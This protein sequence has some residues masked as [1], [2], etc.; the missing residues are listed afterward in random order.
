MSISL[1]MVLPR[2]S[3]EETA[4]R[5]S[6]YRDEAG[7]ISDDAET[8]LPRSTD[9]SVDGDG[10]GARTEWS[11]RPSWS[12]GIRSRIPDRAVRYWTATVNWVKG[13]DPPRPFRIHPLFPRIQHAPLE[14]LDRY[15]PKRSQRVWLLIGLYI[16]WALAFFLVLHQSSFA[17]E[18]QGQAPIRL[19]CGARYVGDGNACGLNGDQCR[20]FDH[21]SMAFR[22]P[23]HCGR[24]E[25]FRPHAVGDQEVVYQPLVVGG[26]TNASEPISSTIYRGD[27]FICSAA[28]HAG[29]ISDKEGG[30]GMLDLVGEQSSFPR[31]NNHHV[32]SVGFDSYFP[33][34][35]SFRDG[36][37]TQCKDMRWPVMIVGLCFSITLSLFVTSPAV[38]FWS[39]FVALFFQ[40]GLATDPPNADIYSL[41]SIAVGRFLPAAFC[42][43]IIYRYCVRHTLTNLTA[44]FEKTVL[45]LGPAWVGVL[46]NYTFD[47]IPIQRLTPHD[48]QAQPGAIPALITIVLVIFFI[49]LGQA[50]SFRVEGRMPRYLAL[51]AL[52]VAGLLLCLAV[53]R[54]FV[55]IHHYILA[56]LLLPGTAFQNRPSLVYQG[57]L[58]GLFIN[59]IARWG[60]DSLLQT[61]GEILNDVQ[62]GTLL[63]NITVPVVGVLAQNITFRLGPIPPAEK[64]R[65]YDGISVLVNDVERLRSYVDYNSYEDQQQPDERS[66]DANGNEAGSRSGNWW[67]Q[68]RTREWTWHRHNESLPEYFRFA[69]LFGSQVGDYT[70]AGKWDVDGSWVEM[71]TG[72]SR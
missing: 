29:F 66:Q 30:C 61:S 67:S 9:D 6:A 45:W 12:S 1:N 58:V 36:T 7:S 17:S 42:A 14:L 3:D 15:A 8:L 72:P 26:P 51:Y 16:A 22:C 4:G 27:S 28:V 34:S 71:K 10:A 37:Q 62:L 47:R 21:Q 44:Q 59:G 25:I 49:A 24:Q 35:F 18:V 31:S 70:K 54:M 38:F 64:K 5:P 41:I 19:W 32:Q 48:L 63:P 55:R 23:A 60:F 57:L 11:G 52:F 40:T 53:P 20:P 43:A 56:L 2:Y 50:W 46:N 65:V 13:P 69:Y 33:H 68:N 39:L